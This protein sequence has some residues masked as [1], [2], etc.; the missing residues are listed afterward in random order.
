MPKFIINPS[1]VMR[2]RTASVRVPID[3]KKLVGAGACGTR[4]PFTACA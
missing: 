4:R 3:R 1:F 2:T